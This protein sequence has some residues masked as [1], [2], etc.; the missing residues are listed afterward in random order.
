MKKFLAIIAILIFILALTNPSQAD[1]NSWVNGRLADQLNYNSQGT[2]GKAISKIS[3]LL[4]E[5][6]TERHNYVL[7][8]TY[9]TK[10]AN[11]QIT[12]TLGI[13]KFFINLK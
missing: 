3:D 13:L 10:L 11:T 6:V 7:F 1:Y 4:A 2:L 5:P 8:S 12:K 9:E